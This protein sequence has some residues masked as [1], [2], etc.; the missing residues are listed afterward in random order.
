MREKLVQHS[1]TVPCQC[2]ICLLGLLAYLLCA[3]HIC[4]TMIMNAIP[5]YALLKFQL[6][7]GV[8]KFV[9]HKYLVALLAALRNHFIDTWEGKCKEGDDGGDEGG[10]GGQPR[11]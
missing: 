1:S 10:G 8:I 6:L 5:V 3:A 2:S 7:M 4:P 9:N 11:S